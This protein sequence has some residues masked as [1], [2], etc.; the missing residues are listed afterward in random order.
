MDIFDSAAHNG[1]PAGKSYQAESPDEGALVLA[2]ATVYGVRLV[3]RRADGLVLSRNQPSPLRR[4][5]VVAALKEGMLGNIVVPGDPDDRAQVWSRKR[6]TATE[7]Q[8]LRN[9]ARC[10]SAMNGLYPPRTVKTMTPKL[11]ISTCVPYM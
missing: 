10:V 11:H 6:A 1:A 7:S 2:A 5:D 8:I 9:R 4:N 3:H